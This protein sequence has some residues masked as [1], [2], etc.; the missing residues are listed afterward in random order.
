MA[1]D[2]EQQPDGASSASGGPPG[3]P[4]AREVRAYRTPRYSVFLVT[5]AVLGLAVGIAIALYGGSDEPS[6]SATGAGVLGYFAA[7]GTLA[8]ALVAGT[9]A[10]VVESLLNR[11]RRGRARPDRRRPPGGTRRR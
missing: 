1:T 2:D 7:F 3:E 4:T 9:L 11:G 5:G 8:G 10:V 6:G